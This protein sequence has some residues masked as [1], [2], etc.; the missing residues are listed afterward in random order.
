MYANLKEYVKENKDFLGASVFAVILL[1]ASF[2]VNFYA[3]T[4]AN[5]SVS[6]SVTDLILS[7]IRTFDLDGIFIYGAVVFW[8]FI[9]FLCLYRPRRIPFVAKSLALFILIRSIFITLTHIAP[10]VGHIIIPVTSIFDKISFDGDLFFSGHTGLPFLMALVFW[11]NKYLR[12]LFIA[13]SIF[14][15]AVVL[16]AHLHYSIDVLAAFFITFTVY[17]MAEKFFK[18]DQQIF[19]SG[20]RHD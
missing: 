14:F 18:K 9:I 20:I 5:L 17:H 11:D 3:G 8:M 1:A 19:I 15:G 6:N 16:M 12:Y 2:V 10:P 13:T 4:Y 7:H